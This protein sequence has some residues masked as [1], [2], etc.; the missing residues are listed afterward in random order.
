MGTFHTAFCNLGGMRWV[1]APGADRKLYIS[2]RGGKGPLYV[3]WM[4]FVDN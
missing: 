3:D 2:T 4:L 1:G